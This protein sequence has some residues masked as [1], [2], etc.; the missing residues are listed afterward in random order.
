MDI[1]LLAITL[2]AEELIETAARICYQSESNEETRSQFIKNIIKRGHLSVLEHASA[3]FKITGIS[4]CCANQLV[5]HRLCSFSQKSQRYVKEDQ[6]EFVIPH[7][8]KKLGNFEE[9]K[10]QC[11]MI[12]IQQMYDYWKQKGIKNEDSRFVLPNSA[13]TE[14]VMSANFREYRHIFDLRCSNHAQWEIKELCLEMLKKLSQKAPI[15]FEDLKDK[16]INI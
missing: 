15:I 9:A 13:T 3:T 2:N 16:Y 11:D 12:K 10:F 14:L 7:S 4:R 8:I 5:R 6:F 1:N